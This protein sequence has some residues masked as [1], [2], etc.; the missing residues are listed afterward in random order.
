MNGLD[1]TKTLRSNGYQGLIVAITA[2]A[3]KEDKRRCVD[4][5]CDGF[6]SKP[7]ER[8]K[9]SSLLIT[10]LRSG[11]R[12]NK[13]LPLE[14]SLLSEEP[15]LADLVQIYIERLPGIISD[16][17]NAY[18]GENW[19]LLKKLTH[20]L[21]STGG[22][23]GYTPLS[24]Y[25]GQITSHNFNAPDKAQL[26]GWIKEIKLIFERIV[27]GGESLNQ[28]ISLHKKGGTPN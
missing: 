13:I 16:I 24:D 12:L 8:Y 6:L 25:A 18:V 1:V 7:I 21:K 4:A 14:S 5:G 15:D 28:F 10:L 20:D 23:Y 2:N 11:N 27:L 9:F 26:Q 3:M 17:E 19:P 22:N